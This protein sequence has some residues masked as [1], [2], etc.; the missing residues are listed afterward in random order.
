MVSL[1]IFKS[2]SRGMRYGIGTYIRELTRALLE[3]T[4]LSIFLVSYMNREV[5][6][7]FLE[8]VSPGYS[9]IMIPAPR[10]SSVQNS[11]FEK[12]YA[13]T[14]VN[15]LSDLIPDNGEVVFQMNYI[16][17]LPIIEKLKEIYTHPVIS[18]VHFAQWQQIFVA[19]KQ[20]LKGLNIEDPSNDI[21]STLSREKKM[22][23]LSDHVVSVTRYMKDFFV[24][25]YGIDADKITV[26]PNGLDV[27]GICEITKEE[28]SKIKS[29]LGFGRDEKIIVFSGRVDHCKGISFLVEAF[30]E[31]RKYRDNLRL[32]IIGQ[33]DIQDCMEKTGSSYG[34]ITYT[35]FIPSDKVMDFYKIADAGV[36]PS[37]YDHCPYTVLEMMAYKIP[38]ILSKINGLNEM[39]DDNQC[40][41]ID[42]VVGEDGRITFD[43]KEIA[44]S[45]LSI[46]GDE[47]RAKVLTRDYP[48]LMWTRFASKRMATE[49][50]AVLKN[51][52]TTVN[53]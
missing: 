19:N 5:K 8:T 28:K 22:Y 21:E 32:V 17:D 3:Y 50:D 16:G 26:V 1:F 40:L 24:G 34:K 38:L 47:E 12:R 23:E 31:A 30:T 45:I 7:F 48:E 37:I 41:F 53:T 35:G 4:D 10:H 44:E 2:N 14:V 36:V 43:I 11:L 39:L 49:L 9:K 18:V 15:L 46:T 20:K 25:E 51:L 29:E 6:E 27:A 13:I 33:G 52:Y 42:P